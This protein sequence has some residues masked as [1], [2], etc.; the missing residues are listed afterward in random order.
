MSELTGDQKLVKLGLRSPNQTQS[1]GEETTATFKDEIAEEWD[2]FQEK[3]EDANLGSFDDFETWL[4]NNGFDAD[5]AANISNNFESKYGDWSTYNSKIINEYDSYTDFENDFASNSG[6]RSTRETDTGLSAG[7]IKVYEE[8]GVGRSGQSIPAGGVE[9]YGK[10]IHFSQSGAVKETPD[11]SAGVSDPVVWDNLNVT[12]NLP[13]P[14]ETI[15]VEADVTNNTG[16]TANTVAQLLVDGSVAKTRERPIPANATKT[17]TFEETVADIV[18]ETV[19]TFDIGI[20][21]AGTESVSVG[22]GGDF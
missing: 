22:Y 14:G 1:A 13:N 15:T 5:T 12:P 17:I 8:D 9:V 19:G 16:L 11:E 20:A 21:K 2:T 7:G 10:E 18:P 6:F 4:I 3:F